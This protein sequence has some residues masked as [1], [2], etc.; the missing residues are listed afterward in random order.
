MLSVLFMSTSFIASAPSGTGISFEQ[1]TATILVTSVITSQITETSLVTE[2]V[3]SGS[4]NL[5]PDPGV[6]PPPSTNTPFHV[7]LPFEVKPGAA[8]RLNI[9]SDRPI[10]H[11]KVIT[12]DDWK[13]KQVYPEDPTIVPLKDWRQ[14]TSLD[15]PLNISPGSY[16]LYMYSESTSL[17][18]TYIVSTTYMRTIVRTLES[19]S[20]GSSYAGYSESAGSSYTGYAENPGCP[21]GEAPVT[22]T[23]QTLVIVTCARS[24]SGLLTFVTTVNGRP[25]STVTTYVLY[26]FCGYVT[27]Q[28]NCCAIGFVPVSCIGPNGE[29]PPRLVKGYY[30]PN[31]CPVGYKPVDP[32][33][34]WV[35]STQDNTFGCRL[36]WM[37]ISPWIVIILAISLSVAAFASYLFLKRRGK[38]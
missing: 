4:V 19:T 38:P 32:Q 26:N 36:Q 18:A 2:P 14:V 37:P 7:G 22:V 10:S 6:R 34:P 5:W 25:V 3:I 33:A 11:V 9:T 21:A 8:Y 17:T 16:Y 24:S 29:A 23:L 35:Y 30:C 31:C 28:P 27:G 20:T 13:K 12:P 15:E 1:N